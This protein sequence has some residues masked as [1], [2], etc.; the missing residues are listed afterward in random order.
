MN[1]LIL[2]IK[3]TRKSGYVLICFFLILP[4]FYSVVQIVYDSFDTGMFLEVFAMALSG[5]I[6][7]SLI[8]LTGDFYVT[9]RLKSRLMKIG[10]SKM[11]DGNLQLLDRYTDWRRRIEIEGTY[12]NRRIW[13]SPRFE[14]GWFGNDALFLS[15]YIEPHEHLIADIKV[16][17]NVNLEMIMQMVRDA[18]AADKLHNQWRGSA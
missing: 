14:K 11:G 9:E 7:V 16:T 17:K 5:G 3:G 10:L 4:L 15:V 6:G 8:G 13:I 1:K 18:L 12:E 2:H